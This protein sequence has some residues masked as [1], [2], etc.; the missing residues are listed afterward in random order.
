MEKE[1]V[2]W[3]KNSKD[4]RRVQV[5]LLFLE[6]YKTELLIAE[7]KG[8]EY[9]GYLVWFDSHNI[10]LEFKDK[11]KICLP[12]NNIDKLW[13]LNFN[14]VIEVVKKEKEDLSL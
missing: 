4:P 3:S 14:Q 6:H 5:A 12:F 1:R 10:I 9:K 2:I 11:T 13:S 7:V 8:E